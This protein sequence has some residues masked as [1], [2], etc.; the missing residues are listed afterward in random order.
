MLFTLFPIEQWGF[1]AAFAEGLLQFGQA[2][3]AVQLRLANSFLLKHLTFSPPGKCESTNILYNPLEARKP[4]PS[5]FHIHPTSKDVSS[6][7]FCRWKVQNQ[8]T[9]TSCTPLD[10]RVVCPC[11]RASERCVTCRKAGL[12][13]VEVSMKFW[14]MSFQKLMKMYDLETTHQLKSL[15]VLETLFP[16][17]EVSC[18]LPTKRPF[19]V[20]FK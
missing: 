3:W 17:N 5:I 11:S 4:H 13:Q 15:V 12:L 6:S 10:A 18:S 8:W 16:M 9:L 14:K 19:L 1:S 2:P 7:F 20:G